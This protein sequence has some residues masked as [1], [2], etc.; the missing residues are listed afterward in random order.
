MSANAQDMLFGTQSLVDSGSA[1]N[2]WRKGNIRVIDRQRLRDRKGI[3]F[4]YVCVCSI[5]FY[6]R[7]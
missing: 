5:V 6:V 4:V 7:A 1:A 2:R 3:L